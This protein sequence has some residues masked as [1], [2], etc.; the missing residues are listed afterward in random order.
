MVAV[1]S[2]NV[3]FYPLLH[4][5]G[6]QKAW[7]TSNCILTVPLISM[8]ISLAVLV[9]EN[10]CMHH[11]HSLTSIE[12]KHRTVILHLWPSQAHAT[13]AISP[14]LLTSGIDSTKGSA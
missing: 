1:R 10:T 13:T 6:F 4:A 14:A 7:C 9:A 2:S 3:Q 8:P 5:E 12:Q 11:P